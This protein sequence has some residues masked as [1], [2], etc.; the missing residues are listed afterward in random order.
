MTPQD[1]EPASP[2]V[3]HGWRQWSMA[4]AC[5]LVV[6]FVLTPLALHPPGAARRGRAPAAVSGTLS[7]V[8]EVDVLADYSSLMIV[9]D[10]ENGGTLVWLTGMHD[11]PAGDG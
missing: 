10:S 5:A 11:A 1:T 7:E 8:E 3:T 4:A 9:E 2:P 6:A